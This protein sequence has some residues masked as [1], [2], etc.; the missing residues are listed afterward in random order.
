[1]LQP[2]TAVPVLLRLGGRPVS[3]VGPVRIY[4]CGITPY[5]VTHLGHASTFVWADAAARVLAWTGHA[6][7]TARNVTD[8]DDVL[9]EEAARQGQEPSL[10]GALQRASFDLTMSTL[11]VGIPEYQPTAA[12]AVRQVIRLAAILL[13]VGEA[14]ERGGTVYARTARAA[15]GMDRDTAL[16]LSAEYRDEPDDPAKDDP[17][18]VAVWRSAAKTDHPAFGWPSPWGEGR[19]GWHA[20]CAAMVLARYGPGLDLHCGGADLAYPH[21]AC[22]AALAEAATGVTPF[23]QHWLRAGTVQVGGEKMAKSSGN[24]V[25]V[26]DL[27]RD[28]SPATVRLLCLNRPYADAWEY[29][30]ALLDEAGATLDQL[31]SA[32]G[33]PGRDQPPP[34]LRDALLQD[35]DVPRAIEIALDEGGA[36]A[37]ALIEVLM[38]G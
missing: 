32:A 8:V 1:M 12:Q 35:L 22:E 3:A 10:F 5:G 28:H 29:E 4:V 18:D 33:K 37:R 16:A 7:H 34:P 30:P 36:T 19:P 9:Y 38:L 31:Y 23:A 13:A 20:G 2:V 6:V 15:A 17:L 25:L 11:R 24:L 26:E 27:L 21:H 14:Y